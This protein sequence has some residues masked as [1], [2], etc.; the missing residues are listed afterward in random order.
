MPL[1][2]GAREGSVA[3]V[4]ACDYSIS[5][6]S[7][8]GLVANP[9]ASFFRDAGVCRGVSRLFVAA[10]AEWR[11]TARRESLVG[12]LCGHWRGAGGQQNFVLVGGSAADSGEPG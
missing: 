10:E 5:C 9:P 3:V 12:D 7:A 4:N 8:F 11:C 6:L 1:T 2:L